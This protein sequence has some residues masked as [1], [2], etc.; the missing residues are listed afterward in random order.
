MSADIAAPEVPS[1]KDLVHA[2]RAT[3]AVL[4][5]KQKKVVED[6]VDLDASP[7]P[8]VAAQIAASLAEAAASLAEA[9]A[10]GAEA[11]SALRFPQ[12]GA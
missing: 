5:E 7:N 9:A 6:G 1:I 4:L 12:N 8:L 3:I 10:S 11:L 2:Q